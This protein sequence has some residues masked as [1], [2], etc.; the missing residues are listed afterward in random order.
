M[1]I[2]QTR[3]GATAGELAAGLGVTERAA[4]RYVGILRE[5][6]IPVESARGPYGGYRQRD[7]DRPT[8]VVEGSLRAQMNLAAN[9]PAQH[10][11]TFVPGPPKPPCRSDS[12]CRT[13]CSVTCEL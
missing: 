4:R 13:R 2:L 6:G 8:R 3:P 12:R 10:M 1:E 9:L 7:N 5:A 11:Q